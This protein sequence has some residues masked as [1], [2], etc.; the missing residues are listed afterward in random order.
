[1]AIGKISG[2]M[3]QNN[4]DRQGVDIQFSTNSLPLVYMDF[5]Q[6]KLGVNTSSPTETLTINGNLGTS[7][8]ILNGNTISTRS[9]EAL[10]YSANI[11]STETTPAYR[12]EYHTG[13][14]VTYGGVSIGGN[15][16]VQGN[17]YIGG[18]LIV[19]GN[20]V[21]IDANSITITDSLIYLAVANETSDLLDIG[22]VGHYN[23]G[24]TSAHTGIIRDSTTKE[25][26]VF[27]RYTPEPYA[28]D[29]D[30]TD[31]SFTLANLN[32][33]TIKSGSAIVNGVDVYANLS[34]TSSNVSIIQT[35]LGNIQ[36]NIGS[37]SSNVSILQS[38]AADQA[39][40]INSL[41]ANVTAANASIAT[42]QTQVYSNANVASYLTV[43]DGNINAGN[44]GLSGNLYTDYIGSNVNSIVTFTGSSAIKLPSGGTSFRPAGVA[45]DI[46][47]NTDTS[48]VE[49]YNGASWI[50]VTNTVTDQ[51]ITGDG[52][53]VTYRLEQT[54]TN[55]GVLVSING[56]LQAPGT[57][58][59]VVDDQITFA[60]IP[61]ITDIIDVRF[62]GGISTL[63]TT[64]TDDLT[65]SGNITLSGI[66]SSPLTTKA[67]NSPGTAGQVC[68]DSGYIYV[69]TA[70]N[71]WKRVALTSF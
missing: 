4:L 67:N 58:Y 33:A 41:N 63:N 3:L 26:Y 34:T 14:I 65:V 16:N 68:W 20:S 70:T 39:T 53:N 36:S 61:L 60:E 52:A 2:P 10:S 43:F 46:R 7:N 49:Y 40:Y 35:W 5:A 27:E 66:L 37:T 25:Y 51:Q 57:A 6:F 21:S 11:I 59:T 47:Y 69:C 45:G 17:A 18:N 71:T 50:P 62:L 9:S 22:F 55:V 19:S 30:I 48:N 29:I 54:T 23:D 1:M 42:L 64:L 38:N 8:I 13:A 15:L 24:I 32:V 12:N 44:I 28:N 31:P 56:T